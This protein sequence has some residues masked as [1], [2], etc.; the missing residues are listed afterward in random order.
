MLIGDGSHEK[1]VIFSFSQFK[2]KTTHL[3]Y[4]YSIKMFIVNAITISN[5]FENLQTFL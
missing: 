5:Q 4:V 2:N 3:H 1:A